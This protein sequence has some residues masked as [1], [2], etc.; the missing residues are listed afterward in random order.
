M[1]MSET[2]VK[3]DRPYTRHDRKCKSRGVHC[4]PTRKCVLLWLEGGG[5]A[6]CSLEYEKKTKTFLKTKIK[7]FRYNSVYF[8][9][10]KII[11]TVLY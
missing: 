9:G 4:V 8:A 6:A 5:G 11:G 2:D 7:R 10:W 1:A 3:T